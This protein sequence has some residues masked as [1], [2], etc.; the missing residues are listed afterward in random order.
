MFGELKFQECPC[1]ILMRILLTISQML[2]LIES[3]ALLVQSPG[4]T[5]IPYSVVS[6][7]S[8]LR[9]LSTC[10]QEVLTSWSVIIS[11]DQVTF[12]SLFTLQLKRFTLTCQV[13]SV[14]NI[15]A[16]RHFIVFKADSETL[17]M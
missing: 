3:S 13:F 16:I 6:I 1:G 15:L 10:G 8:F 5:K 17:L 11:D 7:L 14:P 2:T 9:F 12:L 4:I